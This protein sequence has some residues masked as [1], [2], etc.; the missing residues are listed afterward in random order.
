MLLWGRPYLQDDVEKEMQD[1]GRHKTLSDASKEIRVQL[2]SL[3]TNG[4]CR[5]IEPTNETALS[6]DTRLTRAQNSRGHIVRLW[7]G[8]VKRG[9]LCFWLLFQHTT[10]TLEEDA[11]HRRWTLS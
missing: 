6:L 5:K 8:F 10:L 2:W 11:A 4:R 3:M 9:W 1:C 7:E